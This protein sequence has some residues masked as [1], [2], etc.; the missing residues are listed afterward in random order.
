MSP[1]PTTEETIDECT[2][3]GSKH[4]SRKQVASDYYQRNRERILETVKRRY[5]S[6]T[7]EQKSE[8]HEKS[9]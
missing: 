2:E 3:C 6:M 1:T 9:R 8:Y 5:R 7:P 4:K